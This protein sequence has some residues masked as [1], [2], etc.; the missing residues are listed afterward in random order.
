MELPS[1]SSPYTVDTAAA[2]P[3]ATGPTVQPGTSRLGQ[4]GRQPLTV[5]A[6]ADAA[7]GAGRQGTA[8]VLDAA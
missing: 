3:S 8:G 6:A 2:D 7:P 1:T 5:A 4:T